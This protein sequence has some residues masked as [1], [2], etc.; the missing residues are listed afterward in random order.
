MVSPILT[1][2]LFI[3]PL[4]TDHLPRPDLVKKLEV[5][6]AYPLTLISAAA[7]YG[8]TTILSE[9]VTFANVPAAWISL[10]SDDNDPAQFLRYIISA[11]QT[12]RENFGQD[13]LESL[14]SG[15]SGLVG[16]YLIKLINQLANF[17]HHSFLFFDDYHTITDQ[18]VHDIVTFLVDHLPP[19]IHLV[20]ASRVDPPW[21]LARYRARNQLYELRGKDLRFKQEEIMAFLN[22]SVGLNLSDED[23]S[24]IEERTE[25]WVGILINLVILAA[26]LLFKW[27]NF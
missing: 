26:L 5:M 18:Q 20:F 4:R 11:L 17:Q 27:P 1:T 21:P 8:K 6:A 9:W 10:D 13:L 19:Q 16:T 24:A 15:Q 12:V 7:G 2:K 22:H 25:G 14:H 3:P 23:L